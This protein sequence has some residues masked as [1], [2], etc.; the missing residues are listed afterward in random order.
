MHI[1]LTLLLGLFIAWLAAPTLRKL[2]YNY[3]LF[4][5]LPDMLLIL[6]AMLAGGG[7]IAV[8]VAEVGFPLIFVFAL[9]SGL[10]AILLIMVFGGEVADDE[11]DWKASSDGP[12]PRT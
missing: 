9:G 2:K 4:G 10:V 8:L 5:R 12:H 1:I 3:N 7:L 6:F 11:S